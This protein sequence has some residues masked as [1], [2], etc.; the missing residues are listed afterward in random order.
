V[1]ALA[2]GSQ[3]LRQKVGTEMN[4]TIYAKPPIIVRELAREI[5]IPPYL[6]IHDLMDMDLSQPVTRASNQRWR[7]LLVRNTELPWS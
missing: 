3:Q 7:R 1:E 2:E 4:K 6:L 5:E